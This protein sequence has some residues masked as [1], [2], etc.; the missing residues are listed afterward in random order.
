MTKDEYIEKRKS[1]TSPTEIDE[2]DDEYSK[3]LNN[4]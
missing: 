1:L 2:L 4:N 3:Q